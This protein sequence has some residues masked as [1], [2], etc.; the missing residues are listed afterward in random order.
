MQFQVQ[1]QLTH[2]Q[3]LSSRGFAVRLSAYM[4]GV[5]GALLFASP[6]MSADQN[7]PTAQAR[8]QAER[9]ACNDGSSNQ[10][11]STCLREAA[12]AY[13]EARAGRFNSD[14]EQSYGSNRLIRCEP[15]PPQYREECV[16]R[17]QGEGSQQGSVEDGGILR[18]LVTPSA[19]VK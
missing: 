7:P 3:R 15:L 8:Y 6:V 12:A 18:E 19:P 11:R 10:D 2:S 4:M 13:Q 17:M 9:A 5:A 1:K 14:G 16:R